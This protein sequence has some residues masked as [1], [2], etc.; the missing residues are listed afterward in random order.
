M[1]RNKKIIIS[2]IILFLYLLGAL[3]LASALIVDSDFATIYPG[4]E[5]TI[6]LEVENNLNYDL[7]DV[8]VSLILSDVP[9][10]SVGSSTE[11]IDDIDEDDD[12]SASFRLRASSDAAPGDY[13]IPYEI[14]YENEDDNETI[15]RGTFGIRISARTDLDFLVEAENNIIGQQGQITLEIINK[16]LGEIKAVSVEIQPQ[17][18]RPISK[19]KVFLGNIDAE[20][21]DT[22][23]FDV[24]FT[25]ANPTVTAIIKYKDFDNN[26]QTETVNLQTRAY[27]SEEAAD[28]GLTQRS[29]FV[30]WIVIVVLLV[31]VWIIWRV[32]RKRRKNNSKEI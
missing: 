25:S 12:E 15:Q 32:I 11:I 1:E 27:T 16:G 14:R 23:N 9:F 17:G 5:E 2:G 24:L 10:T 13:S 31:I 7:K 30:F 28:L 22:V 8:S 4:E 19:E 26:D 6:D 18:F 21:S 20:D 3:H 29:N